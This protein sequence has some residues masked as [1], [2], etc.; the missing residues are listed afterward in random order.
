M[1][2]RGIASS[3]SHIVV[4]TGRKVGSTI[5]DLLS[6]FKN[7]NVNVVPAESIDAFKAIPSNAFIKQGDELLTASGRRLGE[8]SSDFRSGIAGNFDAAIRD[9]NLGDNLSSFDT[10]RTLNRSTFPDG[11]ILLTDARR[12]ADSDELARFGNVDSL[13]NSELD[14]L[15]TLAPN[16]NPVSSLWSRVKTAGSITLVVGATVGIGLYLSD[17]IQDAM[18]LSSGCFLVVKESGNKVVYRRVLGYTCGNKEGDDLWV[19]KG[20]PTSPHPLAAYF[21]TASVCAGGEENCLSYCDTDNL[22]SPAS[23]HLDLIPDTSTLVCKQASISDVFSDIANS[24]GTDIGTITGG[25]INGVG[26][27]IIDALGFDW[28]WIVVI[29]AVI[30]FIFIGGIILKNISARPKQ[31]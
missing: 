6:V 23:D 14:S 7:V 22:S 9:I 1:A 30:L 8:W 11:D 5:D 10:L 25:V 27:G 13:S 31:Q 21:N 26:G 16:D 4:A 17:V 18:A 19:Q 28:T 2:Q 15:S 24:I 3:I 29:L 12:A 20:L